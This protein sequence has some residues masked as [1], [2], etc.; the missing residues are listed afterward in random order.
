MTERLTEKKSAD[1]SRFAQQMRDGFKTQRI[2]NHT[3]KP[4]RLTN[5]T[6]DDR[7]ILGADL[8]P[9]LYA[10]VFLVAKKNSGKT[11][12]I[13][14]ILA[15]CAGKDTTVMVFSG[16][17]YNDKQWATIKHLVEY[18]KAKFKAYTSLYD[19]KGNNRLKQW[20]A[21]RTNDARLETDLFDDDSEDETEPEP[22]PPP[23]VNIIVTNA[24]IALD[25]HRA[26]VQE[27]EKTK[28]RKSRKSKYRMPETI[29]VFD[30]FAEEL[31]DPIIANLI[32]RHRHY[33]TK[34]IM[35]SQDLKDILPS[36][37]ANVDIWCIF[38]GMGLKR[39]RDTWER[40]KA[41]VDFSTFKKLYAKATEK[42]HSFLYVD[43][44]AK[45]EYRMNFT[46]QFQI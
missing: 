18:R 42:P 7:P 30:D 1:P 21:D 12:A 16:S 38:G 35:S 9:H 20:L 37:T 25:P 8:I 10:S 29:F 4:I 15:T 45:P 43:T 17:L 40:T 24:A 11:T 28:K 46:D 26:I 19:A 44:S 5:G 14:K 27:Q 13:M 2:N 22:A 36:T 41:S 23:P 32:K 3:V 34:L 33:Y 6:Q 39:L 31:K